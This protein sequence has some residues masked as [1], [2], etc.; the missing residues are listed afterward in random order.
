M[1]E[2]SDKNIEGIVTQDKFTFGILAAFVAFCVFA[3]HSLPIRNNLELW[4]WNWAFLLLALSN[5]GMYFMVL[6]LA[7]IAHGDAWR[8][9][10]D[11]TATPLRKAAGWLVLPPDTA[12]YFY[13]I[14]RI[15]VTVAATAG[16]LLMALGAILHTTSDP[17]LDVINCPLLLQSDHCVPDG[18]V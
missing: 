1:R 12:P 8:G 18:G 2:I 17:S 5:L 3:I 6:F 10:T 13:V 4:C 9:I 15:L 7:T 16:L 14:L 11:R